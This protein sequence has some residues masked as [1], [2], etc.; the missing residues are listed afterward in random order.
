MDETTNIDD[1]DLNLAKRNMAKMLDDAQST[2]GVKKIFSNTEVLHDDSPKQ[3]IN[4]FPSP[5]QV[6]QGV[7]LQEFVRSQQNEVMN[8]RK[9]VDSLEKVQ[10]KF[11]NIEI[12]LK[13]LI[14]QQRE[15]VGGP[16][17]LK[18]DKNIKFVTI[19]SGLVVAILIMVFVN[20]NLQPG[21]QVV[22]QKEVQER[23][24]AI[25]KG[26]AGKRV[27]STKFV[28]LRSKPSTRSGQIS[29]TVSPNRPM[30]VLG[31]KGNWFEVQ[32][33]DYLEEKG[34]RGWVY[35]DFLKVIK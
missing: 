5:G 27:V 31:K 17:V 10:A 16:R 1:F 18:R 28:N 34:H 25:V 15:M 8:L 33:R 9:E 22:K 26:M 11:T 23:R 12:I 14:E 20:T 7:L 35:G 13:Q 2:G 30:E 19:L 24:P 21:A 32:L 6:D 3:T 29:Y 4:I